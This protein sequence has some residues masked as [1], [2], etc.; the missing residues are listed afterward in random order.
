[1]KKVILSAFGLFVFA[2]ISANAQT[3]TTQTTQTTTATSAQDTKTPVKVE[4]L[5]EAVKT[6]ITSDATLKEWTPTTAF[7]VKD[8]TGKEY[9]SIEM[10]KGEEKGLLKLDK[11]GKQVK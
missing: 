8:A 6:S 10:K 7:L 5:P 4:E 11:E 1:M 9:Y 3:T 2:T